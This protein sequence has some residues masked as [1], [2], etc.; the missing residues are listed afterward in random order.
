[1]WELNWYTIRDSRRRLLPLG[2]KERAKLNFTAVINVLEES[3]VYYS[4]FPEITCYSQVEENVSLPGMQIG[5]VILASTVD[6]LEVSHQMCLY[7]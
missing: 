5:K 7:L 6:I 4:L 2:K 1:M 3:R